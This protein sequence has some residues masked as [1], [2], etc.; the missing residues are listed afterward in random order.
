[1]LAGDFVFGIF[2]FFAEGKNREEFVPAGDA[3]KSGYPKRAP[4]AGT[5]AIGEFTG[6]ALDFNI[7]A[8]GAMS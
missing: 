1:V 3:A 7:A 6:D 2:Y 8:D 5:E 4:E